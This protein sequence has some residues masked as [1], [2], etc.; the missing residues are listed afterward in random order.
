LMSLRSSSLLL[1]QAAAQS[2]QPADI[3]LWD[4]QLDGA[5]IVARWHAQHAQ[6]FLGGR[7]HYRQRPVAQGEL[8][9]LRLDPGFVDSMAMQDADVIALPAGSRAQFASWGDNPSQI[10]HAPAWKAAGI[11]VSALALPDDEP[12]WENPKQFEVM[13]FP[14]RSVKLLAKH[15]VEGAPSR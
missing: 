10:L 14:R 13:V 7:Y 9:G 11:D 15:F 2:K 6:Q 1:L 8:L 12:D 5:K 4:A 3:V